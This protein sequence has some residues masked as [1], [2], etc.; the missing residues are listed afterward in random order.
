MY[1]VFCLIC[2]FGCPAD[3]V[4]RSDPSSER[5]DAY[6]EAATFFDRAVFLK[7]AE[8]SAPQPIHAL[9]PLIVRQRSPQMPPESLRFDRTPE[10]IANRPQRSITPIVYYAQDSIQ[11]AGTSHERFIYVWL[12]AA[13]PFG[14][15]EMRFCGVRMTLDSRG[16]PMIYETFEHPRPLLSLFVSRSLEAAAARKFGLPLPHRRHAIETSVAAYPNII[17]KRVIDEGP[18]PMGPYI[19][20]DLDL[21]ITTLLCRCSPSQVGDFSENNYYELRTLSDLQAL[22][23]GPVYPAAIQPLHQDV[24]DHAWLEKVLRLPDQLP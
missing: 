2:V 19:Y 17:V 14:E 11:L 23:G 22:N 18:L 10:E 5:S 8:S 20:L 6:R 12:W 3:P 24:S 7:P 15:S 9:A 16:F 1:I 4:P 13:N 21:Q